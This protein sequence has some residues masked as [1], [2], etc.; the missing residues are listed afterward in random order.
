MSSSRKNDALVYLSSAEVEAYLDEA[1][2]LGTRE[3]DFIGGEP[4]MN[5]EIISM[6]ESAL[7]RGFEVLV[8]TKAMR[9]MR[10]FEAALEGLA[11]AYGEK[12]TLRVSLDHYTK[13]CTKLSAAPEAGTRSLMA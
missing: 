11:C 9:P 6:L 10:R 1:Q 2:R 3:I 8:L 5:R 12:L 7:A 13:A 4:F